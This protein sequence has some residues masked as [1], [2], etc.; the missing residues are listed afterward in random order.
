MAYFEYCE[1][2]RAFLGSLPMH[3]LSA[4]ASASSCHTMPQ[5]VDTDSPPRKKARRKTSVLDDLA[6]EYGNADATLDLDE[7]PAPTPPEHRPHHQLSTGGGHGH[8]NGIQGSQDAAPRRAPA[9]STYG[10]CFGSPGDCEAASY[11]FRCVPN[12]P[13]GGSSSEGGRGAATDASGA[14]ATLY[15]GVGPSGATLYSGVEGVN[16]ALKQWAQGM[17]ARRSGVREEEAR[18]CGGTTHGTAMAPAR[19]SRPGDMGPA[20]GAEGERVRRDGRARDANSTRDTAA[21]SR[22]EAFGAEPPRG[23]AQDCGP[24]A[25]AAASTAPR[26]TGRRDEGT[27]RRDEG[28]GRRDEGTGRRDEGT[29]RRDEG[30]GRRDE[31]TGRRDEGTG[32]RDEGTGH[33]DEGTG[34]RDNAAERE[35]DEDFTVLTWNLLAHAFTTNNKRFHGRD[36]NG[37]REAPQQTRTRYAMATAALLRQAP[38]ALL[39]QECEPA[40]LREGLGLNPSAAAL[41]KEY[42]AYCCFGAE[43]EATAP[44]QRRRPGVA[45]LLRKRGRLRRVP[46]TDVAFVDG[47]DL[48]GGKHYCSIAVLCATADARTVWIGGLHQCYEAPEHLPPARGPRRKRGAQL[49]ELRRVMRGRSACGRIVVGGDFNASCRPCDQQFVDMRCIEAC[50]WL[51]AEEMC[52]VRVAGPAAPGPSSQA[53]TGLNPE[54]DT[55]VALD[56]VYVSPDLEAVRTA[57]GGSPKPPY[58]PRDVIREW[59]AHAIQGPSDHVWVQVHVRMC[60]R[61]PTAEL[62]DAGGGAE[63]GVL[64]FGTG[65]PKRGLLWNGDAPRPAPGLGPAPVA[66]AYHELFPDR[67]Q[68]SAHG[69][70]AAGH[71]AAREA[72]PVPAP[73]APRPAAGRAIRMLVS[74]FRMQE[75][76]RAAVV[77]VTKTGSSWQLDNGKSVLKDH[78]GKSWVFI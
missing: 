25:F 9:S 12:A 49:Q 39:L 27:G 14:G 77:G 67:A 24:G 50:T 20:G 38:D 33:R 76:D 43:A 26:G 19:G 42:V 18:A 63:S 47:G 2:M 56:H 10:R 52:R 31:G 48:F 75:G 74:K 62:P 59:G 21:P 53:A 11:P 30:T 6:S 16:D 4:F 55:P 69:R 8:A 28:T 45:L 58:H 3:A 15:Y 17:R 65:G 73:G 68:E 37:G 22:S 51:A 44:D 70:P 66:P 57:T 54:W 72:A 29:G 61:G 1:S 13:P 64:S 23:P 71:R 35:R 41:L 46:Q 34:R 7:G 40:F 60:G 78:E 32:H 5:N 36:G